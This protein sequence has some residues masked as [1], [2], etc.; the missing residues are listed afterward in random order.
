[1]EALVPGTYLT[2]QI[3]FLADSAL[4]SFVAY[5]YMKR[6]IQDNV[7]LSEVANTPME[8]IIFPKIIL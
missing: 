6:T 4:N 2:R 1:M 7:K 8:N 5:E 3:D